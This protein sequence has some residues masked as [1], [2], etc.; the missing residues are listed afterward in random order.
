[1]AKSAIALRQDGRLIEAEKVTLALIKTQKEVEGAEHP[2]TV[3]SICIL[4]T[5]YTVQARWTEARNLLSQIL[6]SQVKLHGSDHYE[7]F[8]TMSTLALVQ[9]KLEETNIAEWLAYWAIRG[10][11]RELK[12][13]PRNVLVTMTYMITIYLAQGR[14]ADATAMA[15]LNHSI[16]LKMCGPDHVD[17]VAIEGI[18]GLTYQQQGRWKD[19]ERIATT[20]LQRSRQMLG[21]NHPATINMMCGLAHI[22]NRQGRAAEATTMMAEY[23]DLCSRVLGPKSSDTQDALKTLYEW[24]TSK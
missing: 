23:A 19:A 3:R 13:W 17:T 15:E 5:I 6:H 12:R 11:L 22:I 16:T 4:S 24:K 1:M 20:T 9:G 14:T 18:L 10:E 7:I 8:E 21:P 2:E